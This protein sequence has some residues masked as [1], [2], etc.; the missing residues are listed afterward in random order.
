MKVY[1]I[2]PM[3]QIE[4]KSIDYLRKRQI[5]DNKKADKDVRTLHFLVRLRMC[6]LC[7]K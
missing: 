2:F 1:F 4:H 6:F 7:K 5:H 3:I